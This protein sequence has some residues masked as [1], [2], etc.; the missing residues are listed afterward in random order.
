[1]EIIK[2]RQSNFYAIQLNA[3]ISADPFDLDLNIESLPIERAESDGVLNNIGSTYSHE[4]NT[5][6]DGISRSGLR[7]VSFAPLLKYNL[8]PIHK[9]LNLLLEIGRWG[10][11]TPV[12]IEFAVNISKTKKSHDFGILQIRPLVLKREHEV[13]DLKYK[14]ENE[15]LC[16]SNNALGH[17]IIQNITHIVYID[18]DYLPRAETRRAANEI[19]QINKE[20]LDKDINYL[21]IGPGRW[22]SLDPWLGIPVK[23]EHICA[24][25]TIVETS[26]KD[27]H[28]EPSQGSHFFH[29][30]TS[31]LIGYFTLN[32]D[33]N[34]SFLDW[35]WLRKQ[36]K[37]SI[38]LVNHIVLKEP[39]TIKINGKINKG[40]IFKPN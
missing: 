18:P 23:W 25:K 3:A 11:G 1:M 37:K 28:V 38:D 15:I 20:L 29:N 31:F 12:E 33:K 22:G 19:N 6:Y 30:L 40:I 14:D 8:F 27:I 10:M 34:N 4:N 16:L 39:L 36:E 13:L 21:L 2:N 7:I 17:G 9:I 35:N 26:F 5:I 24:A 32:K